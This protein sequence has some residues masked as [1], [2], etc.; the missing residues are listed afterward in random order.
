MPTLWRTY[1][2][3]VPTAQWRLHDRRAR[4]PTAPYAAVTTQ[5]LAH[6]WN[7]LWGT[8]PRKDVWVEQLDD[9]RFQVRWRGGDW[10]DRDGICWRT[11]KAEAWAV[12]KRLL[13]DGGQW[14]R[15]DGKQVSR[16]GD[17]DQG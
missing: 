16:T 3:G 1:R 13:D 12:V 15:V 8:R 6:W 7:G 9:G 2:K 4:G 10:T 11:T 5:L 14:R 17:S